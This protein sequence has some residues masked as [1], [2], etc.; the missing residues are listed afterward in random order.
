MT[1]SRSLEV[2][3]KCVPYKEKKKVNVTYFCTV[4]LQKCNAFK[5]HL[6]M[7]TIYQLQT[8]PVGKPPNLGQAEMSYSKGGLSNKQDTL[9]L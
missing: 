7:W 9:G 1:A 5:Q 8:V 3:I 2:I 6:R 4:A